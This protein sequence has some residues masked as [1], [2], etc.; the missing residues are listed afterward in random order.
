VLGD[1]I[2]RGIHLREIRHIERWSTLIELPNVRT[3]LGSVDPRVDPH[4]GHVRAVR[5]SARAI[6]R[7]NR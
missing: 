5:L 6:A 2:D 7:P 4:I 3:D 1:R